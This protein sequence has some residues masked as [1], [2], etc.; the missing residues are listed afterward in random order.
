MF[1]DDNTYVFNTFL[2]YEHE[3]VDIRLLIREEKLKRI[4]KTKPL[5]K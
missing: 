5:L 3:Y 1:L 2:T 4:L